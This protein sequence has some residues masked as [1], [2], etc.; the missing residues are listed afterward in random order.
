MSRGY[1][2]KAQCKAYLEKTHLQ[3][4]PAAWPRS[5]NPLTLN[6]LGLLATPQ[7][8]Q[9][10]IS[11]AGVVM[12]ATCTLPVLLKGAREVQ[13]GLGFRVLGVWGFRV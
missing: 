5:P 13:L 9:P 8:A 11:A 12:A 1:K 3:C 6:P 7:V 2:Y 4:P 10:R